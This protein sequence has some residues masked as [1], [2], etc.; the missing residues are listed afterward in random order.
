MSLFYISQ[1]FCWDVVWHIYLTIMCLAGLLPCFRHSTLCLRRQTRARTDLNAPIYKLPPELIQHVARF[2][3]PS[4]AAAFVLSNKHFLVA[5]GNKYLKLEKSDRLCFL[6]TMEQQLPDHLL[7]HSCLSFHR[8]HRY[9]SSCGLQRES[10]CFRRSGVFHYGLRGNF[11]LLFSDVQ[12]V[13]NHHRF[14]ESHGFSAK[15]VNYRRTG[16]LDR[17]S[18]FTTESAEVRIS[19]NKLLLRTDSRIRFPLLDNQLKMVAIY[20]PLEFCPHLSDLELNL[21]SFSGRKKTFVKCSECKT[22]TR[23]R[24]M[25]VTDAEDEIHTTSWYTL[26]SCWDSFDPDDAQWKVLTGPVSP[27]SLIPIW[28]KQAVCR[29]SFRNAPFG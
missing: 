8:R 10:L 22:E 23:I 17:F 15:E 25:A 9:R 14:G 11:T 2:L 3:P 6:K 20:A 1:A 24:T 18:L 26:G 16:K 19:N 12:Q 27:C 29:E 13:M 21:L 7:C 4:S 5:L 28:E